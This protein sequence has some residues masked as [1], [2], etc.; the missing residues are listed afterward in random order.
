MC[1]D[2]YSAAWL[3]IGWFRYFEKNLIR[4]GYYLKTT[5]YP[6]KIR[7]ELPLVIHLILIKIWKY[8]LFYWWRL[9]CLLCYYCVISS[10]ALDPC[11][12]AMK[13]ERN[14]TSWGQRVFIIHTTKADGAV[15]QCSLLLHE[16]M[17]TIKCILYLHRQSLWTFA[18]ENTVGGTSGWRAKLNVLFLTCGTG[19]GKTGDLS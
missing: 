2:P 17:A 9:V 12:A 13:R 4:T 6:F 8:K 14:F 7:F 10:A 11:W 16:M 15:V 3:N 1:W 18:S 19:A 5:K